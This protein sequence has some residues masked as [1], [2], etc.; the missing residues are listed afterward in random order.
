MFFATCVWCG[1]PVPDERFLSRSAS[2]SGSIY[3]H[4]LGVEFM[5]GH[6]HQEAHLKLLLLATCLD[7]NANATGGDQLA[8]P[9]A[10]DGVADRATPEGLY[11]G[12]RKFPACIRDNRSHSNDENIDLC[13]FEALALVLT[14]VHVGKIAASYGCPR[15][16][17]ALCEFHAAFYS[18]QQGGAQFYT[19]VLVG[20]DEAPL[21]TCGHAELAMGFYTRFP[22]VREF[23]PFALLAKAFVNVR[24][25]H[26][27]EFCFL[28]T[29]TAEGAASPLSGEH[30]AT[31]DDDDA[32]DD[33]DDTSSES[34]TT[35]SCSDNNTDTEADDGDNTTNAHRGRQRR[36]A[37]RQPPLPRARA[38]VVSSVVN[39][40]P[41]LHI[42]HRFSSF[43]APPSHCRIVLSNK[44]LNC[45]PLQFLRDTLSR[46]DNCHRQSSYECSLRDEFIALRNLIDGME[47][48]TE[49]DRLVLKAAQTARAKSKI[50]CARCGQEHGIKTFQDLRK[51]FCSYTNAM[52]DV[53]HGGRNTRLRAVADVGPTTARNYYEMLKLFAWG[54]PGSTGSLYEVPAELFTLP[55][56]LEEDSV[57]CQQIM[58]GY[59]D[60]QDFFQ[61]DFPMLSN[62]CKDALRLTIQQRDDARIQAQFE[63]VQLG[64]CDDCAELFWVVEA[65]LKDML[66]A[67]GWR[68]TTENRKGKEAVSFTP[69][70]QATGR[71]AENTNKRRRGANKTSAAA[72]TN[73]KDGGSG[74]GGPLFSSLSL[75]PNF[76]H[77]VSC[78]VCHAYLGPESHGGRVMS[79]MEHMRH[80]CKRVPCPANSQVCMSTAPILMCV[81]HNANGVGNVMYGDV[82]FHDDNNSCTFSGSFR[83]V[84]QHMCTDCPWFEPQMACPNKNKGRQEKAAAEDR[85]R[86]ASAKAPFVRGEAQMRLVKTRK[87]GGGR[88]MRGNNRDQVKNASEI[89]RTG[90]F[91][92]ALSLGWSRSVNRMSQ[93]SEMQRIEKSM[94]L[95][96]KVSAFQRSLDDEYQQIYVSTE[97]LSAVSLVV[98]PDEK[99]RHIRLFLD[100]LA[101]VESPLSLAQLAAEIPGRLAFSDD[102]TRH[103]VQHG[104]WNHSKD[105][106][107]Y[108]ARKE[109]I[110]VLRQLLASLRERVDCLKPALTLSRFANEL[111]TVQ[112]ADLALMSLIDK[113]TKRILYQD[114]QATA[115][116]APRMATTTLQTTTTTTTTT[117]STLTTTQKT[118][119][120]IMGCC[121]LSELHEK[122]HSLWPVKALQTTT[123]PFITD[124]LHRKLSLKLVS[125][126]LSS[127][128]GDG[129]ACGDEEESDKCLGACIE[130]HVM[131][132]RKAQQQRSYEC[133]TKKQ[134]KKKKKK[135]RKK[136]NE[137]RRA[138]EDTQEEQEDYEDK[139]R[140]D[141]QARGKG[142]KRRR[143]R[144]DNKKRTSQN[145]KRKLQ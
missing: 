58:N 71:Q 116:T 16:G 73:T 87:N 25:C 20:S 51:H 9:D 133:E 62:A 49:D 34:N 21:S 3:N 119:E 7:L 57:L 24:H 55:R 31:K 27:P 2:S 118:T 79:R 77:H 130:A 66:Y 76:M 117:T 84:W 67:K 68:E 60:A 65:H 112:A 13:A 100:K 115:V 12:G 50:S 75:C 126:A 93:P 1:A 45:W 102:T 127:R 17:S 4:T 95:H 124:E 43:A 138:R 42:P 97:A 108:T 22:H 35:T 123:T 114:E 47:P 86:P 63:R 69:R 94:V 32:D 99:S 135:N 142:D 29:N 15:K 122:V 88:N 103:T 90:A 37:R 111:S 113:L 40:L 139:L 52:Y 36:K 19:H 137:G 104:L 74:G 30:N 144:D 89:I 107:A 134:M 41:A 96:E 81:N 78:P 141:E 33:D 6:C 143:R 140:L 46:A 54:L 85:N 105:A 145:K 23:D 129:G 110:C 136:K 132:A 10:G 61:C 92:D 80:Q 70:Q 101:S 82:P 48:A 5:C 125:F 28:Q 128:S 38:S 91:K 26:A 72:K 109:L 64:D 14:G 98:P 11:S 131:K 106:G 56:R 53:Q 44:D 18:E 39:N 59:V 121:N 120:A 83:E 8:S